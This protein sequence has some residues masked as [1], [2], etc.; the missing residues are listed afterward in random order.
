MEVVWVGVDLRS[1]TRGGGREVDGVTVEVVN[2]LHANL[3]V[4]LQS[5]RGSRFKRQLNKTAQN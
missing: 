5:S 3:H 4:V 2:V 1:S